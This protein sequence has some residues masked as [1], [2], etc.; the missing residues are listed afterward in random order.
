MVNYKCGKLNYQ[1]ITILAL[2][3]NFIVDISSLGVYTRLNFYFQIFN[4]DEPT[5]EKKVYVT[6]K[7]QDNGIPQLE[8]ICTLAVTINDI[9]DNSPVFDK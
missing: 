5:R 3:L 9:N 6:I 1:I 2:Y 8:A 7:A 4:R